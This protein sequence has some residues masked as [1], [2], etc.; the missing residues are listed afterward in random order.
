[1]VS[2][3]LF[4]M[5]HAA[6]RRPVALTKEGGAGI[7]TMSVA[8]RLSS[9]FSCTIEMVTW[10]NWKVQLGFNLYKLYCYELLLR[11]TRATCV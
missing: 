11:H 10:F 9:A 1:M 8:A 6:E 7:S 5:P 2:L 3:H 4:N